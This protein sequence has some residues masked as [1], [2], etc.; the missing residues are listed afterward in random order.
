ME[1]D[2]VDTHKPAATTTTT[3]VVVTPGLSSSIVRDGGLTLSLSFPISKWIN[4]A[5]V[6]GTYDTRV[7]S[8]FVL[9]RHV[10][11]LFPFIHDFHLHSSQFV[12]SYKMTNSVGRGKPIVIHVSI[13]NNILFAKIKNGFFHPSCDIQ[14]KFPSFTNSPEVTTKDVRFYMRAHLSW[15]EIGNGGFIFCPLDHAIK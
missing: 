10:S 15:M 5:A 3:R 11:Y 6:G 1:V 13:K 8:L 12:N 14:T 2:A 9:M 4:R 7:T